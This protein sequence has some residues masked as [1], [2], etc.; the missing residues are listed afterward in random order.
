MDNLVGLWEGVDTLDGSTI[1]VSIG[2][3]E[4]DKRLEF[5]WHESFFT[6]CFDENI[7]QGRGVIS[8]TVHRL[9]SDE[10]ELVATSFVCFDNDNNE[11]ELDTFSVDL[12]YSPNEDI[13]TRTS[14]EGFPGFILYPVSSSGG[15]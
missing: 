7:P 3:M 13:L 14:A 9:N 5:R 15:K 11:V 1:R 12:K 4:R 2:D 8:G 10:I 6:G